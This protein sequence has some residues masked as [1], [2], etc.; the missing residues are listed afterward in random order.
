MIRTLTH[1]DILE[2]FGGNK[3]RHVADYH[4]NLQVVAKNIEQ[5]LFENGLE[6]MTADKPDG[7][8]LA[9]RLVALYLDYKD[10]CVQKDHAPENDL[11]AYKKS[12][13]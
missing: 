7:N 11:E 5:V 2:S 8:S 4:N 12:L 6:N 3:D 13:N 10:A 9:S 1:P